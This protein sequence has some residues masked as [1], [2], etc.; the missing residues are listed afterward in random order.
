VEDSYK[1]ISSTIRNRGGNIDIAIQRGVKQGDPLLSPLLFNLIMEPLFLGLQRLPGYKNAEETISVLAFADDIFLVAQ[2]AM[3]AS[4]LLEATETYLSSLG[5]KISVNKC[6][7][8]QITK[9]KD[10]WYL[11][12][13][14]LKLSDGEGIPYTSA[15]ATLK[16]LGMKISS[17]AEVDVR[18]LKG[19]LFQ[20]I[21][22]KLALKPHQKVHLI[23][24]YL[25][26]QYLYQLIL[27]MP[28]ATFLRKLD[29]ELRVIVKDIYN[30]PQSTTNGLIYCGKR[31]GGLG[32]PR[33][34]TLVIS[35]S[36]RA[37]EIR[38]VN[39]LDNESARG[40]SRLNEPSKE[41]G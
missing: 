13:P 9:T 8:F 11:A 37:S 39:G 2:T 14:G 20:V 36:L 28:P 31:D 18:E 33:L 27:A 21:A 17:W 7:C 1:R 32:F 22:R 6:A 29:Q 15:E 10:S 35:S 26:S 3:K 40:K 30:L 25:I 38:G 16:Y 19:E 41:P 23:S 34:E 4:I 24:T 5:M 12:D